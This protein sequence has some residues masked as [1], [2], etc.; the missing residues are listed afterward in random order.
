MSQ[1][2]AKKTAATAWSAIC[3]MFSSQTRARA[4]NTRLALATAQKGQ[5]TIAEYVGK[6]RALGDEMAAAGRPLEDE[7]LVEYILTGLDLDFN[8]IVT[9]LVARQDSVTVVGDLTKCIHSDTI[10]FVQSRYSMWEL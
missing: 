9:S 10:P 3:A 2:A 4:V 1:I 8:P 5:Q 7:E 6:M